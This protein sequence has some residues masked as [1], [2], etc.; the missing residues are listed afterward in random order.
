MTKERLMEILLDY[1]EN[2]F[3]ASSETEYIR[4]ALESVASK[5]EI[6]ELGFGWLYPEEC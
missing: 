3:K 2:D 5:E 1:V 4:T 6:V